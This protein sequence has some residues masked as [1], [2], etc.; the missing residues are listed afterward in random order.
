MPLIFFAWNVFVKL[1]GKVRKCYFFEVRTLWRNGLDV[2]VVNLLTVLTVQYLQEHTPTHTMFLGFF[3]M[4]FETYAWKTWALCSEIHTH[5][6]AHVS[7]DF[8]VFFLFKFRFMHG[9]RGHYTASKDTHT[10]NFV[11]HHLHVIFR[12]MTLLKCQERPRCGSLAAIQTVAMMKT[13]DDDANRRGEI[14]QRVWLPQWEGRNHLALHS[15][16]KH[17]SRHLLTSTWFLPRC[18]AVTWVVTDLDSDLNGDRFF[19]FFF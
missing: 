19:F 3:F 4:F 2:L 5:A 7:V 18:E 11:L 13:D 8:I 10:H 12:W 16:V 9:K 17:N 6:R 1:Q 15:L 14:L